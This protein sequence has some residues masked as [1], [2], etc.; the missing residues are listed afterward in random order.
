MTSTVWSETNSSKFG[1]FWQKDDVDVPPALAL[2]FSGPL[3]SGSSAANKRNLR[4]E[5]GNTDLDEIQESDLYEQGGTP[6]ISPSLNLISASV[7]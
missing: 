4:L 7:S 6:N 3:P 2:A 1:L 5:I